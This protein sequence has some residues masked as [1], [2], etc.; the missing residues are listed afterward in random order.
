MVPLPLNVPV[1]VMDAANVGLAPTG[2]LQPELIVFVPVWPVNETLL[3]VTLLQV[4]DA[5]PPLS[6]TVP[7]LCVNVAPL[8]MIK[9]VPFKVRF[10]LGAVKLDKL[11]NVIAPAVN[12]MAAGA[13]K[14]PVLV[15]LVALKLD[16]ALKLALLLPVT[17]I[18]VAVSEVN[19]VIAV[20]AELMV[21][22]LPKASVPDPLKVPERD[23]GLGIV[24]LFPNGS[25]Q[26]LLTVFVP[27]LLITTKLK[28]TLLQDRVAPAPSK[29]KVPPLALK[30][31]VPEIVNPATSVMFPEGALNVPPDM[32]SAPLKSAPSGRVSVPELSVAVLE[33][34]N[35]E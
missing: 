11:F 23:T 21:S 2:K 12:V 8:F 29:V 9:P 27:V 19:P 10:P 32:V 13:I 4:N 20:E 16:K 35:V 15:K 30:V 3:N 31:G 25:V 18:E 14:V 26:L 6:T 28:V 24:G 33:F 7:L 1:S 22:V 34:V 17:V 5:L